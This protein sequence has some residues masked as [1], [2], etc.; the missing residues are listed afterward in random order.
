MGQPAKKLGPS[1]A[2]A[3]KATAKKPAA[4]K[5][6]S[7]PTLDAPEDVQEAIGRYVEAK[8]LNKKSKAEMDE[9][10]DEII[11]FVRARQD[12]DGYNHRF[13][14]SY[15]IPGTNGSQVKFVSSNRFSINSD[16]TE[17][18]RQILGDHFDQMIQEKF[19]VSLREEVLEDEGL[20]A[21]LMGL[22]G[23]R[24]GDFFETKQTLAV[25][26]GFDGMI[27]N[28]VEKESLPLLRTFVRQYKPSLR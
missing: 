7:M 20:Q 4:K 18:I 23:D 11:T 9:A 5:K 25:Q 14:H 3:V 21:E 16:D 8:E 22:I 15:A 26:D 24:F 28:V 13:R 6:A 19:Q 2:A 10:G 1:F 17:E 12:E 27:Y